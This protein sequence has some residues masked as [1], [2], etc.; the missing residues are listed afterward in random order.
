MKEGDMIG[1]DGT[2]AQKVFGLHLKLKDR[3]DLER[4]KREIQ[5]NFHI[6]DADGN[7]LMLD[8]L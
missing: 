8:I 5:E 6:Y 3:D 2:S 4:V 7:D 1:P